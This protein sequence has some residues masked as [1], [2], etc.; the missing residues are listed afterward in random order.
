MSDNENKTKFELL[1]YFLITYIIAWALWIPV[2]LFTQGLIAGPAVLFEILGYIAP[3]APMISA[4]IIILKREGK[5][6]FKEFLKTAFQI[7]FGWWWIPV[8]F[9]IPFLGLL[10][11]LIS[12][13]IFGPTYPI[14]SL[15]F[16]PFQI[17]ALLLFQLLIAGGLE[18][19]GWRGYALPRL[20]KYINS[21]F[22]SIVIGFVW[23]FWHLPLFFALGNPHNEY[24]P[25]VL[26]LATDVILSVIMTWMMNNTNKSLIPALIIHSWMNVSFTLFFAEPAQ[27]GNI[28]PWILGL[29]IMGIFTVL[30]TVI[31]G[32][33]TLSKQQEQG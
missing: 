14:S 19:F 10:A 23:G 29:I 8:I 21:L 4:F 1:L 2:V 22:S 11:H 5:S 12:L 25:F 33:K 9:L 6:G 17:L 15:L 16:Q 26:F 30:I 7:K 24:M 32:P 18:E 13:V 27:V 3:L 20:E 28:I 31:Y